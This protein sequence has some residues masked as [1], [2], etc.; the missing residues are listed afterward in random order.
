MGKYYNVCLGKIINKK[1]T[2]L[3]P[4]TS[5]DEISKDRKD[6]HHSTAETILTE[7]M[8]ETTNR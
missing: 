3:P 1:P 6:T 8:S 5:R 4:L 7:K 2:K